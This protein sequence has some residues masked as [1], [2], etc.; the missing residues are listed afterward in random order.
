[1]ERAGGMISIITPVYNVEMYLRQCIESLLGQV[2]RNIEVILV[3]DG[4][5]DGSLDIC[6]EY[7][8]R[9]PRV[10]VLQKE[11]GGPVSAR[12]AGL[13]AAEG[14]YIA[15]MDS[16]DWAEPDMY[17]RLLDKLEKEN[18]DIAMCGRYEDTEFYSKK[19]CHGIAE[20]RYDKGRM[21]REV[22]PRMLTG[23]DFFSWGIFPGQWD[24]LFRRECLYDFQ[25]RVEDSIFMGD[26]AA[27]VYPSLLCADSIYVLGECLYHYRQSTGSLVKQK[28]GERERFRILY[29]TVNRFFTEHAG[30]YDLR[31][32]WKRYLLFLMVPRADS[33]YTGM[34]KLDYLF[35]FPGVKRGSRIILYCAGT[36]GQR[37]YRFLQE[38]GFCEVAAWVDKNC[39]A[40]RRQGL[41]VEPPE[42]I[43][44]RQYDAI[45][46]ATMFAGARKEIDRE[47]RMRYPAGKICGIE[48]KAVVGG[49]VMRVFGLV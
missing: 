45:V 24:K 49:D 18:V 46:I 34:D 39:T 27:C 41:P 3:D 47:L 19:V 43:A 37:L 42:V 16:D 31:E 1:M 7:E 35:P 32:Q 29:E 21:L 17:G 15:F 8:R 10:R 36:Y 22:Y 11:N 26:D 28:G 5:T 13:S 48:D 6:K 12:K 38:T 30:I 25:M 20:G 23:K 9:D 2:Y 40:L 33:L 4:S 44:K 14:E